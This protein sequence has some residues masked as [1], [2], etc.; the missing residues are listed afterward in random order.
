MRHT[1]V[2]LAIIVVDMLKWG[3]IVL[4]VY[5]LFSIPTMQIQQLWTVIAEILVPQSL[6]EIQVVVLRVIMQVAIISTVP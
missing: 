1:Q 5:I 3:L 4:I 2:L 6:Q